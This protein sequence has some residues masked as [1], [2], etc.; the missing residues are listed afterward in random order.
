MRW[1]L[2]IHQ[3]FPLNFL[4]L[5]QVFVDISTLSYLVKLEVEFVDTSTFST[6][7]LDVPSGFCWYFNT[8]LFG[9]AWGGVCWYIN[10]LRLNFLML[11]QIFID[12]SRLSY[13]VKLEVEF[14]DTSTFST[15]FTDVDS[16]F[17]WYINTLIW[18]S[19]RWS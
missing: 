7:F 6:V 11:L 14:V 3:H 13:C 8:L 1:S 15:E 4:M 12:I 9:K 18:W 10:I 16:S 17:C 5:T 19:V 2:L